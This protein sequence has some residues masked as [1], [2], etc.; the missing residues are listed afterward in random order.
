MYGFSCPWLNS[1]FSMPY[2][3]KTYNLAYST[4]KKDQLHHCRRC[5]TMEYV[6][7]LPTYDR[8]TP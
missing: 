5:H 2:P 3:V 7:T 1:I 6:A 4:D 8:F